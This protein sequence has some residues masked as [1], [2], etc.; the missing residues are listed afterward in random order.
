MESREPPDIIKRTLRIPFITQGLRN[1]ALDNANGSQ[2]AI[3]WRYNWE[4]PRKNTRIIFRRRKKRKEI[5][6]QNQRSLGQLKKEEKNKVLEED[7]FE[8]GA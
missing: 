2:E 7:K 5:N 1:C 3:T 8:V 4:Q 6:K